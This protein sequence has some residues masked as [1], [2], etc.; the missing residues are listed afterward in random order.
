MTTASQIPMKGNCGAALQ[1]EQLT[2][3]VEE[4]NRWE[5]I[6]NVAE[7]INASI[8]VMGVRNNNNNHHHSYYYNTA[9]KVMN[10][11]RRPVLIAPLK[12][13]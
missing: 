5:S 13:E 12:A 2:A 9:S 8:I 7:E 4:G 1:E 3:R 11:S 6:I 10:H